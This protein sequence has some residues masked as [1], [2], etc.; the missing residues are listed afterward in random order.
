MYQRGHYIGNWSDSKNSW[1][2][3]GGGG[4]NDL[5]LAPTNQLK[6][7]MVEVQG[8]IM[9]Q[10]TYDNITGMNTKQKK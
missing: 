7:G 5:K 10:K 6:N 1:P 2:S 4:S 3:N 9:S 8:R